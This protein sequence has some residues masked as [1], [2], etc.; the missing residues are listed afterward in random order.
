MKLKIAAG[1]FVLRLLNIP[2]ADPHHDFNEKILRLQ[3]LQHNDTTKLFHYVQSGDLNTVKDKIEEL[4]PNLEEVDAAGANIIHLAYL[5][6]WYHIGHWLVE[7]YPE[8]ALVPYLDKLPNEMKG[9]PSS[10][11]PYTGENILHMVIVRRNYAEVRWLLDFYKDHKDSVPHGLAQLLMNAN[12][13]GTFFDPNGDFYFG[14]Y[15]LQ[16]AVCSNS[17]EIFDLVLSFASSVE[18]DS[19]ALDDARTE[20][21]T[22]PSLGPNVIFMRDSCGNTLL[23]LCV[24]HGLS[25]MFEHVLS[26]ATTVVSRELQCL[27][28]KKRLEG[29]NDFEAFDLSSYESFAHETGYHLPPKRLYLPSPDLFEKWLKTEVRQKVDERLLLVLNNDYF[30]PLTLATYLSGKVTSTVTKQDRIGMIKTV[31]SSTN[32]KTKL[33]SFGPLVCSN[34]NLRGI[35]IQYDFSDYQNDNRNSNERVPSKSLNEFINWWTDKKVT[36]NS[37]IKWLCINDDNESIL[38]PEVKSIID[39]KWEL[40]GLPQFVTGYIL[41]LV[42][43]VLV[44]LQSIF[45]NTGPT[46]HPEY[47]FEIFVDVIYFFATVV[48]LCLAYS[49]AS[50]FIRQIVKGLEVFGV[51]GLHV[52]CRRLK[53]L[54]YLAF[55]GFRMSEQ[56]SRDWSNL[57]MVEG[58]YSAYNS[59]MDSFS[60]EV[61]LTYNPQDYVGTK[62]FLSICVVLSWLNIYYY[63]VGFKATGPFMLTF[64]NVLSGDLPYF[65]RFLFILLAGF[66]SCISMLENNGDESVDYAFENTWKSFLSLVQKA[67]LLIPFEDNTLV[68]TVNVNVQW[69]ANILLTGFYT[70]VVIIMLNLLIAII[71]DTYVQYASYDDS[72]FLIEKYY[73]MDF[74]DKVLSSADLETQREKYCSI[75]IETAEADDSEF[76]NEK[77]VAAQKDYTFQLVEL[78]PDWLSSAS[79]GLKK[80]IHVA[81]TSLLIIDPQVDFLLGGAVHIP[82]SD[83]DCQRIADMIKKNKHLIHEIFVSMESRSPVNISHPSFWV[84]KIGEN[85]APYSNIKYAEVRNGT[86]TPRDKNPGVL[87]WCLAYTKAL[88]R[89]DRKLFLRPVHCLVGSRGH[90]ISPVLNEAL[91]EWASYSNRPVTYIM[92]GQNSRTEMFSILQAQVEDPLDSNTSFNSGLMSMLRAAERV[93]FK[94]LMN[95]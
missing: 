38:L 27:Y 3:T 68:S 79:S 83:G 4:K 6:E 2:C 45:V 20:M 48:F 75:Q 46:I 49:E 41:D 74:Y 15:P 37:A 36:I 87:S 66:A 56:G 55:L 70:V 84:N 93:F 82:G 76:G 77:T 7:S 91:Q 60:T 63:M 81:K 62:L 32:S 24:I 9:Y 57:Y 40:Y 35:D 50:F 11:M 43:V 34:I 18:S 88:E 71:N 14:G 25:K 44:T 58:E 72:I 17:I 29:V 78:I 39:R 90:M 65:F 73:I 51:S 86:W 89:T 10:Y 59:T 47:E 69:L 64:K 19:S 26:I 94:N 16:F 95:M 67:V 8:L 52:H 92:K 80:S 53:V 28:A 12:A 31:L 54:S 42:I 22:A 85:P 33:W 5:Y 61:S 23:H 1:N 21:S 13:T 30:S